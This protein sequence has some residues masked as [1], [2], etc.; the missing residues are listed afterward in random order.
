MRSLKR[1]KSMQRFWGGNATLMV[2]GGMNI[3]LAFDCTRRVLHKGL[4]N[5]RLI[6]KSLA[7]RRRQ[8]G[9]KVFFKRLTPPSDHIYENFEK[10]VAMPNGLE[11]PYN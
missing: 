4:V 11:E 3:F 8:S 10:K 2:R 1:E 6:Y 7:A 9:E 5:F